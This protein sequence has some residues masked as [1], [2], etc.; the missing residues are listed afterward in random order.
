MVPKGFPISWALD[1]ILPILPS[2]PVE[3]GS[4]WTTEREIKTLVG[5]SWTI[6][7]ISST[8]TVTDIKQQHGVTLVSVKSQSVAPLGTM[9]KARTY[10]EG[11]QLTQKA[12]WVFDATHGR[13]ISM[14]MEQQAHGTSSLPQGMV[15][16]EQVTKIEFSL[17]D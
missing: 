4:Q 16:V 15:P 10:E 14:S 13:L 9:A 3:I 5:W 2:T 1:Q 12:H 8:H 6:G 17:A 11:N 7:T